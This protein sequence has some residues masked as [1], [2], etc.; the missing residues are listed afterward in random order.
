M[1]PLAVPSS[2]G[3]VPG[4]SSLDYSPCSCPCPA[5]TSSS[6]NQW[7]AKRATPKSAPTTLC[8]T[9]PNPWSTLTKTYLPFHAAR[10]ALVEDRH[11]SI[12]VAIEDDAQV[13]LRATPMDNLVY[14]RIRFAKAD[15]I[16]FYSI[17][18]RAPHRPSRGAGV[19]GETAWS[20][21]AGTFPQ[22][23]GGR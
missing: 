18:L 15:S 19:R 16:R 6:A 21:C 23:S 7:S 20:L 11:G 8:P 1:R 5:G 2:C 3:G 17:R 4:F 10:S 9:L 13:N 14:S 12:D 22:A